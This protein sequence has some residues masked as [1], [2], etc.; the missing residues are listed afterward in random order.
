MLSETRRQ[1]LEKDFWTSFKVFFHPASGRGRAGEGMLLGIRY[2]KDYHILPYSTKQG[3]LWA[4]IQFRGGEPPL[5]IGTTYIPPTGSPLLLSFNLANR[6]KDI[7]TTF[8]KAKIEGFALLG[9]DFNSRVGPLTPMAPG[10]D[11]HVNSHG[12]Q[13]LRVVNKLGAY[14][15]TGRVAG[16]IPAGI[17]YRATSRSVAT[18]L[19]HVIVSSN[20]LT[21]LQ[22]SH[23]DY[24]RSDSDHFP[25]CT[26]LSLPILSEISSHCTHRGHPLSQIV[27]CPLA[28]DQYVQAL[29]S[30][31]LN[32][33]S[34]CKM[35]IE[36]GDIQSSIRCLY[37]LVRDAAEKSG[38]YDQRIRCHKQGRKRR[39]QPFFDIECKTLKREVW[40]YGILAK[41]QGVE[42]KRLERNY[43]A[44][45]RKK[46][47]AYHA[48]TLKLVV[49]QKKSNPQRFWKT[50]RGDK[51]V[52]PDTLRDVSAW[53]SYIQCLA[54]GLGNEDP[55]HG[56]SIE[57]YPPNQVPQAH[58]DDLNA[59][60]TVE[61]IDVGLRA[62][63]N[64]KSPGKNGFPA[65]LFRYAQPPMP[66]GGPYSP[67]V[68]SPLI[69]DIFTLALRRRTI[70]VETNVRLVTPVYKKG[71]AYDVGNY[72]PIAVGDSLMRLYAN[73]LNSRL[74]S[75]LEN[76][77]LR[78]D[79]QTGFRPEMATTH[80][81]F[82][83]QHL[84]DWAQG[85]TPLHFAF[86]DLSK[87]YDR[88]SRLK[89][90][91]V[92][93]QLG[94]RGDF[95]DA[96]QAVID[97]TVLTVK[98][99]GNHGELFESTSGVPQGCPISP[100]LF[101]VM[102]DGLPRYL[103]HHCPTVGIKLSD[104]TCLSVIRI[105]ALGFADDFALIAPTVEDLQVLV[106]A[107][108]KWCDTMDM[109]L[110]GAKT[111]YLYVNPEP[112]IHGPPT[113]LKCAG[114]TVY[115]VQEAKYLGLR[116]HARK[117]LQASIKALEQRFWIAW[118]DLTRAYSNLGCNMSMMLQVE[119]YLACLPSIISYG[120]E[121]WAFRCFKGK[122]VISGS[123]CSKSL[124][125]A[126][127]RVLAQVLGVRRTTPEGIIDCELNIFPLWSTWILRMVRFWN[128]IAAM[129]P[130]TLHYKV[131]LQD[132]R[133]AIVEGRETFAGT[134]LQQLK[135]LGYYVADHVRFDSVLHIDVSHV[136]NL[137]DRQG[138]LLWDDLDISPRSCPS[139]RALYCRYQRW[140]ARPSHVPQR[141]MALKLHLPDRI[142]RAFMRFR[143]G[144]HNLPI[145]SG[146]QHGIPRHQRICT[147]CSLE[148]V[149]DEHHLLFTCTAVQHVRQ[150]F[151]HLFRQRS[152]S[153][154][155]FMW[156]EDIEG[157]ARFV[158]RALE[159]YITLP[160]AVRP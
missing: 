44:T 75:Y 3:S 142:L 149:G 8:G 152:R 96:I 101:G 74:V 125:Q 32:F 24:E 5:V 151:L 130:D 87:A 153:V 145:D 13:L 113:P 81:L 99:E 18:R 127:K 111:Q 60:F 108:H 46:K 20:L 97:T 17:S 156:Q 95:L 63:A 33:S 133:L 16:D 103:A 30:D 100:T 72:R 134:I 37:A 53:D 136:K 25:L 106:D 65:E 98:I 47:R 61:E 79:C 110:N 58:C 41:W 148:M 109:M 49:N 132:L 39:H 123:P 2:S 73:V 91:K 119:L 31:D 40:R 67:N 115:P 56:L 1:V 93:E 144:C 141:K 11:P 54:R 26:T 76:N 159:S 64:G 10:G 7:Q 155:T 120:C 29:R 143:L 59:P 19:D 129:R 146:R 122:Q 71:D 43:H 28:R 160:G 85:V 9:G 23:I 48:Q 51:T 66:P 104:G 4:K 34:Q 86:L 38:M 78:V 126:H 140:F 154:Q 42:F 102:A 35:A 114:A 137:L 27:W 50:F 89:L 57:A 84:I 147:R 45:V 77:R 80:Q 68:L 6:M 21:H 14:I 112:Q 12:R 105:Q 69:A 52:L 139:T 94:I 117:G 36:N 70:P 92:L 88:V 157:V 90:G 158:T 135:K 128:N 82:I 138:D 107:T 83:V 131:L 121:I 22:H 116:V 55:N 15:C 62:L 118:E 124:L 150:Q